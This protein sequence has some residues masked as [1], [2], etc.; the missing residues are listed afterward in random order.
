[1]QPPHS[2]LDCLSAVL[3]E[4]EVTGTEPPRVTINEGLGDLSPDQAFAAVSGIFVGFNRKKSEYR[5]TL[6]PWVGMHYN[7]MF[8]E[9]RTEGCF[10]Y[11]EIYEFSFESNLD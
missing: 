7:A 9:N 8:T 5:G 2:R 6:L 1:M 4:G 10:E 3:R 11:D